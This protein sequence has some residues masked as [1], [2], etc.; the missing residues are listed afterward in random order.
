M[1]IIWNI[2]SAMQDSMRDMERLDLMIEA[3]WQSNA[4]A[5]FIH[6]SQQIIAADNW[7]NLF[8]WFQ[9]KTANT[10]RHNAC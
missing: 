2:T 4:N 9:S 1:G 5:L 8:S 3:V 10:F 6:Q 7:D